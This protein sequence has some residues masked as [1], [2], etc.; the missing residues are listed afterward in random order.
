MN[1]ERQPTTHPNFSY[2][3]RIISRRR[4]QRRLRSHGNTINTYTLNLI[5]QLPS[6]NTNDPTTR[7]LFY[8]SS[9][10]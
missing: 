4:N 2:V 10:P 3:S 7:Q 8:G 9:F 6:Q 5:R 1:H